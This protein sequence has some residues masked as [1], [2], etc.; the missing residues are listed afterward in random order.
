MLGEPGAGKTPA[1]RT[2][3]IAC[4]RYIKHTSKLAGEPG[5]R[6][7]SDL[8]FC[9]GEVG[10][11]LVP[12]LFDDGECSGQP[13]GS[14]WQL[15]KRGTDDVSAEGPAEAKSPPN[16]RTDLGFSIP[17]GAKVAEAVAAGLDAWQQSA[18]L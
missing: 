2:L 12:D 15:R 16:S 6:S 13:D 3:A 18:T 11:V 5:F 8:D 9:R 4:A 10:S 17:L 14:G 7:A 1:G